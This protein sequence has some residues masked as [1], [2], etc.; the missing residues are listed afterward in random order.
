MHISSVTG[1]V[2]GVKAVGRDVAPSAPVVIS[3]IGGTATPPPTPAQ[4]G[5]YVQIAYRPGRHQRH[6][7]PTS[8]LLGG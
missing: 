6:D 7:Y 8:A 5:L 2:T 3:A 1:S 4:F